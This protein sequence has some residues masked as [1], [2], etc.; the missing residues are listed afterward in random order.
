L[1]IDLSPGNYNT[2]RPEE[3]ELAEE[4]KNKPLF[5]FHLCAMHLSASSVVLQRIQF[6]QKARNFPETTLV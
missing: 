3:K 1:N 4:Y 5:L 6:S 2:L